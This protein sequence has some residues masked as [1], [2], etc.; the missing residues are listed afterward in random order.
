PAHSL[1]TLRSQARACATQ[2]SLPAGWLPW[3]D[4]VGYL[5]D[6]EEG[7]SPSI[8]LH[9]ASPGARVARALGAGDSG[10]SLARRGP[11]T[12]QKNRTS[13]PAVLAAPAMTPSSQTNHCANSTSPTRPG[14]I[15][16]S[17]ASVPKPAP[18]TPLAPPSTRPNSA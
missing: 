16:R 10:L 11:L 14:S 7:F 17:T 8:H 4:R 13:A 18:A 12:G 1:S 3:P 5:Q 15:G 9:Q 2:D 6:S